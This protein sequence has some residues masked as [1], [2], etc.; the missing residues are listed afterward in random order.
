MQKLEEVIELYELQQYYERKSESPDYIAMLGGAAKGAIIGETANV[1]TG[2]MLPGVSTI[3]AI[4]GA[5][6]ENEQSQ[7]TAKEYAKE[8]KEN[9]QVALYEIS[10]TMEKTTIEDIEEEYEELQRTPGGDAYNRRFGS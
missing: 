7:N 5:K 9:I 2:G 1:M 10:Y 6:E 3:T 4:K 8:L